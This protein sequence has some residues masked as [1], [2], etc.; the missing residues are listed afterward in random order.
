MNSGDHSTPS[1][2]LP[3]APVARD[4]STITMKGGTGFAP[5]SLPLLTGYI[6]SGGRLTMSGSGVIADSADE[7][8]IGEGELLDGKLFM[9]F[10]VG[11]SRNRTGGNRIEY[12]FSGDS[13][14]V[15]EFIVPERP[16]PE[17]PQ[18]PEFIEPELPRVVP[19][20]EIPEEEPLPAPIPMR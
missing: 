11:F 16:R 6:L 5:S 7:P 2:S 9:K 8:V 4:G 3:D 12:L 19:P 17:F 14:E 18:A 13:T 10:I 1:P 15:P 20:E